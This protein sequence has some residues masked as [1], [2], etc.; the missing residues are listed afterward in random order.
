MLTVFCDCDVVM[1]GRQG[2]QVLLGASGI[3]KL[4][5][6]AVSHLSVPCRWV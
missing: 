4:A 1:V 2:D 6:V 3:L 5:L